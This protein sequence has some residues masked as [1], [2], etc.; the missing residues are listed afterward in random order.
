MDRDSKRTYSGAE[1]LNWLDIVGPRPNEP[2]TV[3]F[4]ATVGRC[5]LLLLLHKAAQQKTTSNALR[6]PFWWSADLWPDKTQCTNT[7]RWYGNHRWLE[8]LTWNSSSFCPSPLFLQT[9]GPWLPSCPQLRWDTSACYWLWKFR[10]FSGPIC[11]WFL[12]K[13]WLQSWIAST[14]LDRPCSQ[15]SQ[16]CCCSCHSSF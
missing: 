5:Q 4:F 3:F 15:S 16:G 12:L 7:I 1:I 8:T 10:P 13:F 9:L 6:F 2:D 11:V 14:L